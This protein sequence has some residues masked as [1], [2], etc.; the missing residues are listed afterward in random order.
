M[1]LRNSSDTTPHVTIIG[2]GI[3][4][5]CCACYLQREGLRVTVI[6]RLGPGEGASFGNAGGLAY[7]EIIPTSTPGLAFKV[8]G[9]VMD[10][11][12]PLALRWSYLPK[13]APWLIRFLRA[14]TRKRVAEISAG[15]AAL[16]HPMHQ[17][18]APLLQAAGIQDI[19]QPNGC[20]YLYDSEAE[21]AAE[22][23]K[24]DLRREHGI[25]FEKIAGKELPDLEPDMAADFAC[26]M[27]VPG[28]YHVSD[29]YR[30]VTSFA[31]H[32]V[33]NGGEI[34]R[35]EVTRIESGASG[36][37]ALHLDDGASIPVDRLVIAAGAWSHSLAAQL[38][39]RVSLESE[40]G[41]HT[42]IPDPGVNP[43]RQ[44]AY[45]AQGFVIT[46]MYMGLR[47]AGTVELAGLVA[48]PNY[49]R[50]RVLL[51][52]AKRVYPAL[53]LDGGSEW[54]GHRPAT[55]DTLPVIGGSPKFPNVYYAFGH[56][57]MGLSW[58][59]TTGRLI[60]ELIAGR[61]PAVD[62]YP[63]RVDRF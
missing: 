55:P 52:K 59:P 12:G 31:E 20:L 61:T 56:G 5:I 48:P 36:P 34:K 58:G 8:P 27:L 47:V 25:A 4:G 11:A 28:W 62:L 24:W 3:V 50:A 44:I 32:V 53:R 14:G 22:Q 10:P 40:R 18:Y 13:I 45:Q 29:P 49:E 26:A 38:G 17:D 41:Y 19:V 43:S 51:P 9:W 2:A 63:Y 1:S 15:L 54:M 30:L 6:D 23:F 16:C 42:T 35:G 37:R 33:R 21:L 46:P 7:G 60:T 39:S 57:H